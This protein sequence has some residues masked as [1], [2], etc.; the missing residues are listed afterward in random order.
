M[1]SNG[2]DTSGCS[3]TT[4]EIK[5]KTLDSQ[6]FTLRVDK[7]FSILTGRVPVP[8]LKEQIASLTGVV[9]DQQ[10][11]ICRGRVLKD[12]QLLSAYHVEDGHTLHMV[13]RQ[14][15]APSSEL[16]DHP[17]TDPTSSIGHN[18]RVM[19]ESFNL[20]DQGDGPFPD[21]NRIVSAV[22]GS[23]GVARSGIGG[24]GEGIDLNQ[25]PLDRLFTASGLSGTGNSARPLSD[26]VESLQPPVIPDSLTTLLQYACHLRQAFIANDR[27]QEAEA[28]EH[29]IE[30]RGILRP[31]SLAEVMSSARQLLVEHASGCLSQLAG[32]LESHSSV[33]DPLERS[34]IQ[35]NAIRSGAL[36]QNLGAMLLELGRA[37]MT[38]RMAQT[39][40]DALV[41]AG[42][43]VFVSSTGP[44]PIMV[45]PLPFQPGA[46]LGSVSVGSG[47]AAGSAAA[48]GFV[49]RNIDIRIRTGS[50]LL[51]RREPSSSSQPANSS[52]QDAAAAALN[53][54]ATQVRAIPLRTVVAGVPAGRSTDTSRGS[55]GILYPVLARV[56]QVS[57]V[58]ISNT[59]RVPSGQPQDSNN[60]STA[61]EQ[62]PPPPPP[63]LLNDQGFA[64]HIRGGL[65]Q[66]FSTTFPGEH[67]FPSNPPAPAPPVAAPGPAATQE[68]APVSDEGIMLSNILRQIMPM[69][70]QN[71]TVGTD[72]NEGETQADDGNPDRA[73]SSRHRPGHQSQQPDSKRQKRE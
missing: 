43:S 59:N 34:R 54:R 26:Q 23:F 19:V 14:P 53:S 36:F 9:S 39:P 68:S 13:V 61:G 56:Q 30:P 52:P 50:S 65:E 22:L 1:G 35:S 29:S 17:A 60:A 25:T 63:P 31:E 70:P 20:S 4:V 38:L 10:R 47:L 46:S 49:P 8:Q 40:A 66:L 2:V 11:L 27:G 41:N 16:S 45:Q 15:V 7:C 62:P 3:E 6:T 5:I 73:S 64:A 21:L 18:P 42:P 51:S 72:S 57:S 71:S 24:A 58:P 12:D 67:L 48:T 69:L 28:A 37:I 33:L 32:Q 44:N 55:I